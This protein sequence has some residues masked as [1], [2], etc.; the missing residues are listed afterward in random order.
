MGYSYVGGMGYADDVK[1][2]CPALSGMQQMIDICV[3]YAR[4]YS[5]KF[6]GSKSHML[7]FRG[8]QCKVSNRTLNM[9]GAVLQCEESVLDLGHKVS[10]TDKCCIIKAAKSSFWRFFNLFMSD[11]GHIYS[12][13]KCKLFQQYCCSFYG[14]PLWELNSDATNDICIAWRK[15]L[16]MLWGLHPMT[17]CNI[18][19]VLSNFRP[20]ELQLKY[21]FICF[22]KKCLNHDNI[23]V[24]DVALLT[25]DNPMSCA[26]NNYRDIISTFDSVMDNPAY[27]NN[28]FYTMCE[29][30]HDIVSVLRD[31]IDIRDGFKSCEYFT[32]DDVEDIIHEICVN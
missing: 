16:R 18:L 4:E 13:L 21:R 22:F 15:A 6:N 17:H 25:L 7:L 11:L 8:R 24:K 32:K 20:L 19:C 1:L 14:S 30:Q 23:I 2:L 27:I 3:Q 31:M 10:T 29:N 9:D 26:G 12:F 28:E 5:V